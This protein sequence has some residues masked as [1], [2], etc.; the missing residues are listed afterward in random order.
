MLENA[1]QPAPVEITTR[2]RGPL[3]GRIGASVHYL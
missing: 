3:D 2:R 1:S